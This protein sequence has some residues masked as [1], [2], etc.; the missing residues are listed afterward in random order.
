MDRLMLEIG[1]A[2]VVF[3]IGYWM[4]FHACFDY[5]ME[6][7][8]KYKNEHDISHDILTDYGTK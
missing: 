1:V 6:E 3:A 8:E 4:G 2:I 7:V 5:L